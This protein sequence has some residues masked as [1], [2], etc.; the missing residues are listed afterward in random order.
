[1]GRELRRR[2]QD[3]LRLSRQGRDDHP[4]ARRNQRLSGDESHRSEEDDRSDNRSDVRFE[5]LGITGIVMTV[6]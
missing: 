4:Q 6:H 1:M 2:Q 3:L 5:A